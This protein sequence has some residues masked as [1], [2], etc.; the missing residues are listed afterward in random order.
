[1]SKKFAVYHCKVQGSGEGTGLAR[2][3]FRENT[4][5]RN[6]LGQ[7]QVLTLTVPIVGEVAGTVSINARLSRP[8]LGGSL[9]AIRDMILAPQPNER[10]YPISFAIPKAPSPNGLARFLNLI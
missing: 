7:E 10:S 6:G 9:E 4:D 1:M 3:D 5:R 2:W 8:G